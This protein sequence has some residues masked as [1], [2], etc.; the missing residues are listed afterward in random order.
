MIKLSEL[1]NLSKDDLSAKLASY[2]EQLSKLRYLKTVGQVDKPHQFKELR[3]TIARI[4]T[5]IKE[6]D[7]APAE[8]V[9]QEDKKS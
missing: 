3:K 5:L 1:R 8:K 9:K 6:N 2:K 7:L 4:M